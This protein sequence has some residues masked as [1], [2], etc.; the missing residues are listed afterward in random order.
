MPALVEAFNAAYEGYYV[1]MHLSIDE[2]DNIIER[3][4][5]DRGQSVVALDGDRIVG[6]ILLGLRGDTGW[7]GGVG[8]VPS[9]RR[10]RVALKMMQEILRRAE[11]LPLKAVQLE[12]ITLNEAAKFLYD[13]LDFE[14]TRRLHLLVCPP[15]A[16]QA[17]PPATGL[18]VESVELDRGFALLGQLEPLPRPW[19]RQD[20][21][22]RW[23]D[24]LEALAA[25]DEKGDATGVALVTG[26]GERGALV[27][28]AGSDAAGRA[29]LGELFARFP[30][31]FFS[32]LNV[33][34]DDPL[35][36]VLNEA[37]FEETLSQFEMV[38]PF[39]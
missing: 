39:D 13:S 17:L 35:L 20:T 26:Q 21:S 27:A 18:T 10:Q 37:G 11:G 8:V 23:I 5:V 30:Q 25:F 19:Q 2:F 15:D 24:G 36:P 1:P 22:L 14:T 6:L 7:I 31:R 9:H 29:L 28:L 16:R 4:S 34:S 33:G 3:E 12:V 38:Y 32:F